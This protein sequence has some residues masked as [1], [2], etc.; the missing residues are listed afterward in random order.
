MNMP[1]AVSC[2]NCNTLIS[3][4]W[5]YCPNCGHVMAGVRNKDKKNRKGWLWCPTCRDNR[6]KR[7]WVSTGEEVHQVTCVFCIV[8]GT[9][10]EVLDESDADKKN[11]TCPTC[12]APSRKLKNMNVTLTGRPAELMQVYRC[13][14]RKCRMSIPYPEEN[15]HWRTEFVVV[16]GEKHMVRPSASEF[17]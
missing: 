8:C 14:N 5:L 12:E 16:D 4:N 15:T 3:P 11:P 2:N 1:K 7:L 6:L 17:S 10:L 9:E 13:T